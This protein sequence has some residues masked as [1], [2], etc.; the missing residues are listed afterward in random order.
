MN[1]TTTAQELFSSEKQSAGDNNSSLQQF[2]QSNLS[3]RQQRVLDALS[4]NSIDISFELNSSHHKKQGQSKLLQ[5]LVVSKGGPKTHAL[6]SVK[7]KALQEGT[8]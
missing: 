8:Q 1:N 7:A 6:T 5:P 4:K 2:E 3:Q